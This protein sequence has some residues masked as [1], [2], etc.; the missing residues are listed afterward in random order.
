MVAFVEDL[1]FVDSHEFVEQC[2][3]DDSTEEDNMVRVGAK[4]AEQ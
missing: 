1:A 4:T 3:D 2:C